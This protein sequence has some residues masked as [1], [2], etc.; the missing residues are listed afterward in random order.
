MGGFLP[1][2]SGVNFSKV[3]IAVEVEPAKVFDIEELES[4]MLFRL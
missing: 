2:F 3:I 1:E 4:A